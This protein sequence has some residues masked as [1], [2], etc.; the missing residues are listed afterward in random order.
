MWCDSNRKVSGPLGKVALFRTDFVD[1]HDELAIKMRQ[2][3]QI[4]G[5]QMLRYGGCGD[6]GWQSAV[7]R[8]NVRLNSACCGIKTEKSNS[9]IGL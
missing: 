3:N 2:G 4:L 7:L 8:K 5:L 1:E 6:F 9:T